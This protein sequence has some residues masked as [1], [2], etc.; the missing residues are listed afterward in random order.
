MISPIRTTLCLVLLAGCSSCHTQTP[1]ETSPQNAETPVSAEETQPSYEV[2]EWGLINV[3]PE[4]IEL[5]TGPGQQVAAIQDLG[6]QGFGKPV[7][8]FHLAEDSPSFEAR[9]DVHLRGFLLGEH[10]PLAEGS[11]RTIH[12]EGRL[13]RDP[14]TVARTY[15]SVDECPVTQ[16]GYCEAAELASYETANHSCFHIGEDEWPLLFYRGVPQEERPTLPLSFGVDEAGNRTAQRGAS[17]SETLGKV[18]YMVDQEVRAIVEWPE[19]GQSVMLSGNV[20]ADPRAQMHAELLEHSLTEEEA[21]AFGRAWYEELFGTV[22]G[23]PVGPDE[24]GVQGAGRGGLLGGETVPVHRLVYWLPASAHDAMA[25][26]TFT[27]APNAV[28]RA[29][30]VRQ[31][32][33]TR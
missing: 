32:A 17:E 25:G 6:L 30:L 16:D 27:P 23:S 3:A 10:Y 28:H 7:L 21:R 9:V 29:T 33:T 31:R 2:H 26:L 11:G 18:W 13:E 5:A 24:R 8:Y 22:A 1:A 4:G 19:P 14:C 12:W 15:P 20:P